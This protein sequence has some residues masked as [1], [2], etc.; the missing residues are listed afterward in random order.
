MF[1]IAIFLGDLATQFDLF[2]ELATQGIFIE[3]TQVGNHTD[4][5]TNKSLSRMIRLENEFVSS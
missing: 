2:G 1:F 5:K 4:P 3:Q